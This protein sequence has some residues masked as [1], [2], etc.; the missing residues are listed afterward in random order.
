MPSFL[1]DLTARCRP[2]GDLVHQPEDRVGSWDL[3]SLCLSS[4][5]L[6]SHLDGK[7]FSSAIGRV[8][9]RQPPSWWCRTCPWGEP[10][11]LREA[12]ELGW[13]EAESTS[14]RALIPCILPRTHLPQGALCWTKGMTLW[15]FS[16]AGPISFLRVHNASSHQASVTPP[17]RTVEWLQEGN[18][19]RT[20]WALL[21]SSWLSSLHPFLM[22][23]AQPNTQAPLHV[24]ETGMFQ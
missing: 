18:I 4:S 15:H 10:A 8:Q 17:S 9:G 24:R 23:L 7:F 14:I 22:T 20:F 3:S 12:P 11:E 21:R 6:R 19:E 13:L 2:L 16:S 1:P 5:S